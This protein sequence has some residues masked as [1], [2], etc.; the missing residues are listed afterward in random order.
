MMAKIKITLVKSFIGYNKK[1]R[2]TVKALGL[3]KLNSSVVQNDTP[4]ILG[5]VQS[6]AHLVKVEEA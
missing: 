2:Q 6:I 1:Q 5:K 4:D 3:T